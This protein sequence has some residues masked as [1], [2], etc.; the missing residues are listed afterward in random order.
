MSKVPQ[1]WSSG[2]NRNLLYSKIFSLFI[3]WIGQTRFSFRL[4][5]ALKFNDFMN[6]SQGKMKTEDGCLE[7][8]TMKVLFLNKAIHGQ[9]HHAF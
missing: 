8:T 3:K 9:L 1:L 4:H 2:F 6:L 7:N 5:K